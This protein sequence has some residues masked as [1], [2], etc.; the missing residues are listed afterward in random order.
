MKIIAIDNLARETVSD[1]LIVENVKSE[2]APM[3]ALALNQKYCT[4]NHSP[5]FYVAVSDDHKLH[6]FTP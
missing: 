4:G 3:I 6:T 5:R 1:Q 2:Y